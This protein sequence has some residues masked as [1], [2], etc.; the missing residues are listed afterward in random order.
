MNNH[1]ICSSNSLGFR[2]E[3]FQ[4]PFIYFEKSKG[5]RPEQLLRQKNDIVKALTCLYT[6]ESTV[7]NGRRFRSLSLLYRDRLVILRLAL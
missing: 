7:S 3:T 2:G 6:V 5:R 1:S 4:N